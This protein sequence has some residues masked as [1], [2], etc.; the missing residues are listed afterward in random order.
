MIAPSTR[1]ISVRRLLALG[2]V[3][4]LILAPVSLAVAPS[5]PA[6]KVSG[7]VRA[8]GTGSGLAGVEV[9]IG[10]DV[11]VSGPDG[12]LP[13]TLIRL[14]GLVMVVDVE[15][16]ADGYALWRYEGV[17]LSAGSA[18][19]LQIKLEREQPQVF[20]RPKSPS[21]L[22]AAPASN[23]SADIP[24]FIN[25]GRTGVSDHHCVYPPD[26]YMPVERVRF[27][28]YARN[29]LPNEWVPGWGEFRPASLEAGAVAVKQFGWYTAF[30]E[31]KWSGRG[32]AWDILD[33]TCDQVYVPGSATAYTDAAVART[34]PVTLVRNG[35]LFA[36]Y[37][38]ATTAQCDS[39]PYQGNCMSQWGSYFDAGDGLTFDQILLR[40]YL[41][42]MVDGRALTPRVFAPL[43]AR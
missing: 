38:R 4:L 22:P 9:H 23:P 31:H 28:D 6:A 21:G 40:Y 14:S 29:V 35:R 13:P 39:S 7:F 32:Y 26:P 24:E 34:W 10:Q 30:V 20:A 1:S 18:V 19:E 37:Y 43:I 27:V 42:A 16:R 5:P 17:T 11:I 25:V 33:S 41:G 3:A 2:F 8:A 12:T 15:T 36:T